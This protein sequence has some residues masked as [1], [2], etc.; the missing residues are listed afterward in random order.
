MRRYLFMAAFL[1]LMGCAETEAEKPRPPEPSS[2]I[3]VE[4]T[5]S[6]AEFTRA[7]INENQI[8]SIQLHLFG[9]DGAHYFETSNGG[10][11]SL[12][13]PPLLY[14][15][16]VIGNYST[17]TGS[18]SES[19]LMSQIC[20]TSDVLVGTT[21]P[22]THKSILDLR[23]ADPGVPVSRVVELERTLAKMTFTINIADGFAAKLFSVELCDVPDKS[24]LM[25]S[26]SNAS[27]TSTQLLSEGDLKSYDSGTIYLPENL[28]GENRSIT[29][30][31]GRTPAAAPANATYL[32]LRLQGDDALMVYDFF[33][34]LGDSPVYD[35]NIRRN[36]HYRMEIEISGAD[37]IDARISRY[38]LL[39]T[40]R[41]AE[42]DYYF[43]HLTADNGIIGS[44]QLDAD[45]D[46][47]GLT[48][49]I[50]F[51]VLDW[52]NIYFKANYLTGQRV[53]IRFDA[54]GRYEYDMSYVPP[55]FTTFN[56]ILT[57]RIVLQDRFGHTIT[58]T[59]Q[60]KCYN[61][62]KI[63]HTGPENL[64]YSIP[65]SGQA[66][67]RNE[68]LL[69][70][71]HT[72]NF[73]MSQSGATITAA[74]GKGTTFTGWFRDILKQDRIS[75]AL[76][77][78]YVPTKAVETIYMGV[79]GVEVWIKTYV[80]QT[81]LVCDNHYVASSDGLHY[82]VPKGSRIEL[83]ARL[84]W[85]GYPGWHGWYMDPGW[86][87]LITTANPFI[88]TANLDINLWPRI[89]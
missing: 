87:G 39:V 34:F 26:I 22:M 82:K 16:Y 72:S 23:N 61:L 12:S 33:V 20:K 74:L 52:D 69:R 56:D 27:Y 42:H 37:R 85:P 8:T 10:R 19:T 35:F 5:A 70:D 75:S 24:G 44:L 43:D 3:T 21:I 29:T 1:A 50:E 89:Q 53:G 81:F 49:W 14:D 76:S 36:H 63:Q 64:F 15:M 78:N 77:L 45:M 71:I 86:G 40:E 68:V 48:G 2:R 55:I 88:Y 67:L 59:R 9:S 6:S 13:V 25:G 58:H 30:Q 84:P 51:D 41:L 18:M 66:L 46:Y 73:C 4:V 28:K 60:W 31:E 65:E 7:G 80:N 62:L 17:N 32:R 79:T 57:Y 54:N 47:Y 38:G 83:E 11:I